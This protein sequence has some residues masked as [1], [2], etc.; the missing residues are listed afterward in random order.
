MTTASPLPLDL[1]LWQRLVL[2]IVIGIGLRSVLGLEPVWWLAWIAPAP[3]LALAYRSSAG[4]ARWSVGLAALIG[5]T[6]NWHFFSVLMPMPLAAVILIGQA[7]IWLLIVML[8]RRVVLRFGA[9]WTV[10]AYPVLWAACDTLMS[11]LLADGNWGSL[12]YTQANFLP[13]LQLTSLLGVSALL[14]LLSLV[15]SALA[16]PLAFGR[17]LTGA[18]RAYGITTVLVGATLVFGALRLQTPPAAGQPT[19]FG[20][21]AIDDWMG[22]NTPAAQADA[23][24]R[25]YEAHIAS[26][27]SRGAQVIVL[28]EKVAIITQAQAAQLQSRFVQ[29]AAQY[30]VWI[31]LGVGLIDGDKHTNLAWMFSPQGVLTQNYQK[32]HMAPPERE[33]LPGTDYNLFDAGGVRYGLAIC[34]DMHFASFGL[35]Q[36]ARGADVLLVP[37]WDFHSDRFVASAI[38]LTRGVEN[39]YAIVR[40]SRDGLLTVTDAHGRIVAQAESAPMPGS[41]MLTTINVQRQRATLYQRIGDAFGWLCVMLVAAALALGLGAALRTRSRARAAL[42]ALGTAS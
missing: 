31:E 5:T 42:R 11:H 3:L 1:P 21:A 9:W 30:H 35:E 4:S 8:A 19:V 10:F 26:L 25:Q 29:L 22:P 34:K 27:A 41:A 13:A 2:V 36:G 16:M 40:A 32:H 7:L 24:W 17:T 39:G 18:W 23:I 6:A 20:L 38:T 15:A 14:F 37:A 28:P 33:Y 12:G